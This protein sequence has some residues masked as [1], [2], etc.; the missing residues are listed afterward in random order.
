VEPIDPTPYLEHARRC[1]TL[2]RP[3]DAARAREARARLP[4]AVACLVALGATKVILFGS[5]LYGALQERSDVDLAVEGLPKE[6]YWRALMEVSDALGR[7]VDLVP[8]EEAL[9]SLA[10]RIARVGEVLH[11]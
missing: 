8:F 6:V 11:V 2:V 4:A 3:E 9:P 1:V 5:L 10:A 7:D